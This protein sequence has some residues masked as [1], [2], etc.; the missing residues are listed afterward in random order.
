MNFDELNHKCVAINTKSIKIDYL[1]QEI[2]IHATPN[3]GYDDSLKDMEFALIFPNCI[4]MNYLSVS[5]ML[6]TEQHEFISWIRVKINLEDEFEP[7]VAEAVGMKY[8]DTFDFY[9]Y[10][11]MNA[12][13]DSLDF[14][15][16]DCML[17]SK[18]RSIG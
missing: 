6:A 12:F 7:D 17:T 9:K 5:N 18:I 13:Q 11:F 2:C 16:G 10:G 14:I 15:A 4:S 8:P 1:K 3:Y